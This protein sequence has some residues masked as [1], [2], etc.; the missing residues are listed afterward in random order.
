M[1]DIESISFGRHGTRGFSM[2][3][4][5]DR[6]CFMRNTKNY[7]F[8]RLSVKVTLGFLQTH[9]IFIHEIYYVFCSTVHM[10]LKYIVKLKDN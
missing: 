7:V 3:F 4:F 10:Y 1:I 9:N 8:K 5:N 6:M 2:F